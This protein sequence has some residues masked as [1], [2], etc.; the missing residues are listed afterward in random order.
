MALI[1]CNDAAV[2]LMRFRSRADA[3]ANFRVAKM[4]PEFQPDGRR[5]REAILGMHGRMISGRWLEFEWCHLTADGHPIMVQIGGES[6]LLAVWHDL[7][8]S[9]RKEEELRAA[10][11]AAEARSEAKNRFLANMSHEL[12]TPMNGVIGVA[13]LLLRT[14]LT[15]SSA[16]TWIALLLCAPLLTARGSVGVLHHV[17]WC[18]P[19]SGTTLI[20]IDVL[21][22]TKIEAHVLV[23]D[24]NPF[25]LRRT[26]SQCLAVVRTA[27]DGKWLK[28]RVRQ[29]LLNL[30]SN[31]IKF[32]DR[33]EVEVQVYLQSRHTWQ[34]DSEAHSGEAHSPEAH[35]PIDESGPSRA[36]PEITNGPLTASAT[37]AAALSEGAA[38]AGHEQAEG[39]HAEAKKRQQR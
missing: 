1:E 2:R 3:L 9:K 17:V 39:A 23:L 25:D 27:A 13:E 38:G 8:E 11:D 31:A 34:A 7:T 12:R 16:P 4:S 10:K 33:G 29:I 15:R 28:F 30:L 5:S 24:R 6:C 36:E 18:A 14:P 32:T 19:S 35:L 26:L 21:D 20:H 37:T 22:I